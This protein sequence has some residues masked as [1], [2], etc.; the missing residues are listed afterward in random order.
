MQANQASDKAGEYTQAAKG[1]GWRPDRPGE[2]RRRCV[3]TASTAMFAHSRL[4]LLY[5]DLRRC[6]ILCFDRQT[7]CSH[8]APLSLYRSLSN[9]L[10]VTTLCFCVAAGQTHDKASDWA[11]TAQDKAG[12][13]MDQAGS[14]A[15]E[16]K[17][18]A[19]AKTE[20]AK[21]NLS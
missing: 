8:L 19:G 9:E 13:A 16:L 18:H 4:P 2:V 12:S 10:F 7:V 15:N 17:H 1:Q 14:K 5:A 20:Q 11:G 6:C 3:N 21:Q